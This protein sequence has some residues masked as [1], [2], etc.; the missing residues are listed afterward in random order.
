M[1]Q[2]IR[3]NVTDQGIVTNHHTINHN[4]IIKLHAIMDQIR[5]LTLNYNAPPQMPIPTAE[6]QTHS[7][8]DDPSH[9]AYFYVLSATHNQDIHRKRPIPI[10][11]AINRRMD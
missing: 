9:L 1:F 7:E 10:V 2:E 11:T 4:I 5:H 8:V 6:Y 3:T